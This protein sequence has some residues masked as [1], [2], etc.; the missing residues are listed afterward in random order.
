MATVFVRVMGAGAKATA[1]PT[2][3]EART[4]FIMM[5][6]LLGSGGIMSNLCSSDVCV[7]STCGMKGTRTCHTRAK[8]KVVSRG[9]W[10]SYLFSYGTLRR[11]PSSPPKNKNHKI[12]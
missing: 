2:R 3:A 12:K 10:F 1:E 6:V 8:S 7:V 11:G 5:L 4:I 9:D